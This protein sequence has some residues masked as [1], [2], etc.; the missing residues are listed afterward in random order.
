METAGKREMGLK[1]VKRHTEELLQPL[2]VFQQRTE[3]ACSVAL[4]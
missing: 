1:K 3:Q 2:P 4:Q